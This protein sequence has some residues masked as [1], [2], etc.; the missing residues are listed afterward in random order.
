MVMPPMHK[1]PQGSS[2]T[3]NIPAG[4]AEQHEVTGSLVIDGEDRHLIGVTPHMHWLGKD[5]LMTAT[6]PDGSKKTLIKVDRWDFDWQMSYDLADP[7]ALPL[8]TRV[9]MVAHFDNSA[10]NPR[11]PTSPPVGV[12]WGERTVD[13]MCIGFL[14]LTRDG[15][16]L[17]NR[18]PTRFRTHA[19]TPAPPPPAATR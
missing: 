3:L 11:N 10:A 15:Q 16:H 6:L 2:P 4:S 8:G 9:D 12:G 18:P 14:H 1:H 17:E 13:E 5:F 19:P 7:V